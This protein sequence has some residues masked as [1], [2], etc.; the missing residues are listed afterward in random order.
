FLN[1]AFAL[2]PHRLSRLTMECDIDAAHRSVLGRP[3]DFSVVA[4]FSQK[5]KLGTGM[6]IDAVRG[7]GSASTM[8]ETTA[9]VGDALGG[10]IDPGFSMAGYSKLRFSC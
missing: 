8:F 6:T 4:A 7:D 10:M 3:L 9:R 2:P 1:N 5:H